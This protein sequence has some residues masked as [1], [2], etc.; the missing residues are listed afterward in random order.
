MEMK[1][2]SAG[3]AS[4]QKND[5]TDQRDHGPTQEENLKGKRIER[6]LYVNTGNGT[7]HWIRVPRRP[8]LLPAI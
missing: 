5:F 3:A 1:T 2:R 6:P 4:A 8:I 7:N